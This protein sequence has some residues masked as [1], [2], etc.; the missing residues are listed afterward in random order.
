LYLQ[1]EELDSMEF[2]DI[3]GYLTIVVNLFLILSGL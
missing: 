3:W 1:L 2:I